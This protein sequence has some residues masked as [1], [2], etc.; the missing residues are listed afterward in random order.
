MLE[1]LWCPEKAQMAQRMA[2]W[3]AGPGWP[4]IIIT[5]ATIYILPAGPALVEQPIQLMDFLFGRAVEYQEP[6]VLY[7]HQRFSFCQFSLG[8][9]EGRRVFF[10]SF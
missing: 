4:S 9:R 5:V 10:L 2:R 3:P 7:G 8:W 6:G 1:C